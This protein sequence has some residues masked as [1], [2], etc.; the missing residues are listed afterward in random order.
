VDSSSVIV[1]AK[2]YVF[3]GWSKHTDT[4][5]HYLRDMKTQD[6]VTY[7]FTKPLKMMFFIKMRDMLSYK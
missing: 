5:F 1:L 2:N 6:Q 7:I 3:H 4:K